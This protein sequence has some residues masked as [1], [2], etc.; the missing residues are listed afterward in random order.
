MLKVSESGDDSILHA[1]PEC[2]LKADK[3]TADLQHI[4]TVLFLTHH[5]DL[6]RTDER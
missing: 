2:L 5:E 4:R 3:Y 1:K 6:P